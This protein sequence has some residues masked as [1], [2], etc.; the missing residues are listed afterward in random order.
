MDKNETP[1]HRF[2]ELHQERMETRTAFVRVDNVIKT[3]DLY[4]YLREIR[5]TDALDDLFTEWEA[6]CEEGVMI[7]DIRVSP[8]NRERFVAIIGEEQNLTEITLNQQTNEWMRSREEE[9]PVPLHP[10]FDP[11]K[12]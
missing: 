2:F 10:Q 8:S 6:E 11:T 7:G 1:T 4:D 5:G 3:Q 9:T 12:E